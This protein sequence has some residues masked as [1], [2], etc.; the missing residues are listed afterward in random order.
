M[1]NN[2]PRR[3][4]VTP[5]SKASFH[6]D[7][8]DESMGRPI[9]LS[10]YTSGKAVFCNCDGEKVEVVIDLTTND[11][12]CGSVIINIPSSDT[13]KFDEQSKNFDFE[14]SDA[15]DT[16]IIPIDDMIEIVPRNCP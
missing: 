15:N 16:T 5:G 8:V 1:S 9:D 13:V 6:V 10:A 14:F 2:Y 12:K 4:V 7:L 3:A 11:A